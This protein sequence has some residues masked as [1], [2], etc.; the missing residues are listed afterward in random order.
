MDLVSREGYPFTKTGEL[1]FD[2]V[3]GPVSKKAMKEKTNEFKPF[4][5]IY[6][7]YP[8]TEQSLSFFGGIAPLGICFEKMDYDYHKLHEHA[9]EALTNRGFADI[10]LGHDM[11]HAY[12]ISKSLK[13]HPAKR[14]TSPTNLEFQ[15]FKVI[16]KFISQMEEPYRQAAELILFHKGHEIGPFRWEK[17]SLTIEILEDLSYSLHFF[18][19]KFFI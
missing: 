17:E 14:I 19:H 13:N 8:F 9:I 1:I 4:I 18:E 7:T 15:N 16:K 11:D 12:F 3:I 2:I 5:P 10:F 6:S